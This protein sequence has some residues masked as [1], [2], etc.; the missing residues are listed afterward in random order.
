MTTIVRRSRLALGLAALL[1]PSFDIAAWSDAVRPQ[2]PEGVRPGITLVQYA[3]KTGFGLDLNLIEQPLPPNG[4][5]RRETKGAAIAPFKIMTSGDSHYMVKLEE[6]GTSKTVLTV[7]VRAG[8]NAEIKVPLGSYAVK[9][10]SGRKWYGYK[11]RF[12]P[13]TVYS[14][15]DQNFQFSQNGNRISGY[16]ITLYPVPGG[17]LSTSKINPNDF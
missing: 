5:L 10:A 14:K 3:P 1:L 7:F 16:S 11:D 2:S 8:Q 15:A 6:S 12:G 9:Y 13:D 4:S 17:N